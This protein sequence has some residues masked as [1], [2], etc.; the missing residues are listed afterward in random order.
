MKNSNLRSKA[1]LQQRV[2][3]LIT[4]TQKHFPTGQLTVGGVTYES[5]TLVQTLQGLGNSI[6]G[7]DAAKAKWNDALKDMQD[8][9][10]KVG[11]VVRAFQSYLLSSFGNTPST[12]AD[13][14]L[15][16]RSVRAPLTVEQKAAAAAKSAATRT[17]RH[18]KG[19]VQK[20]AVKGNVTGVVVTPISAPQPSAASPTAAPPVQTASPSGSAPHTA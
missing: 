10:A 15:V 6:A 8:Q 11:P 16:P 17:A 12:L 1:T 20:K 13:F 18:T 14:G 2:G 3:S 19:S 5:A 7:A 4:G 9:E